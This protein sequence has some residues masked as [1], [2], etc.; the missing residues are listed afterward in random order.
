M[1]TVSVLRNV[2]LEKDACGQYD[3]P[4]LID[5]VFIQIHNT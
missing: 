2:G 5:L 4:L 3:I 1:H